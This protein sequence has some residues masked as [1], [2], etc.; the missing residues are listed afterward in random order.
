[1]KGKN[2]D[3]IEKHAAFLYI[4]IYFNI[5]YWLYNEYIINI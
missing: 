5:L 2:A 3:Y 4:N 1:M